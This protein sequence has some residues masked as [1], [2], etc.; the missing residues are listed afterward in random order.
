MYNVLV[1]YKNNKKG[2]VIMVSQNV[3]SSIL[4]KC[5]AKSEPSPVTTT[6]TLKV[7]ISYNVIA[8]VLK[9]DGVPFKTRGDILS[10]N[11]AWLKASENLDNKVVA[12]A[13]NLA[14]QKFKGVVNEKDLGY[15]YYDVV[16]KSNIVLVDYSKLFFEIAFVNRG[17]YNK[18]LSKSVFGVSINI[19]KEEAYF[20]EED[21]M[22]K[23]FQCMHYR[24]KECFEEDSSPKYLESVE[25]M[26]SI[27]FNDLKNVYEDIKR[28]DFECVPE[29]LN[30][31][32][33]E[34]G[35]GESFL[36]DLIAHECEDCSIQ[37]FKNFKARQS[38]DSKGQDVILIHVEA[39]MY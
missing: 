13:Y 7:V 36:N 34:Y 2:D 29:A 12:E 8:S 27:S 19:D 23:I 37:K 32:F 6:D 5:V 10:F 17:E 31:S 28:I 4:G 11:E 21:Y 14:V 3:I 24:I 33:S 15:S 26:G 16:L 20:L 38:K 18:V 39:I 22:D 35:Y 25:L 9:E 1:K 30:Y